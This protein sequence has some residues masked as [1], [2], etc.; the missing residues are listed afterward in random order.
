MKALDRAVSKT[1]IDALRK[2][3]E[4]NADMMVFSKHLAFEADTV[5]SRVDEYFG[6]GVVCA[7]DAD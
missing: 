6:C 3:G 2:A 7:A 4:K 1:S 5:R